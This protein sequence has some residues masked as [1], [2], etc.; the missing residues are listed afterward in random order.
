MN[1]VVTFYPDAPIGL[2]VIHSYNQATNAIEHGLSFRTTQMCMLNHV[3]DYDRIIIV[4]KIKKGVTEI[5]NNHDGTFSCSNGHKDLLF[6]QNW[7][8]L[9]ENG[10]FE[11][12]E[13]P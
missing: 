3:K 5:I 4:S 8:N 6:T 10:E 9:W 2:F 7:F 12:W 1:K 11:P 13:I